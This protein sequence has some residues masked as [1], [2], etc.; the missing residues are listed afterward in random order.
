M[1]AAADQRAAKARLAAEP[2]ARRVRAAIA[3]RRPAAPAALVELRREAEVEPGE[4]VEYPVA[5]VR[6]RAL[7]EL[8]PELPALPQPGA[9]RH[10][11]ARAARLA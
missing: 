9:G 3:G 11:V 1:A 4:P 8:R 5:R 10:R 6:R 7:A 2:A